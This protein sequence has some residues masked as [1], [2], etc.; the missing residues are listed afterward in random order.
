MS[1]A[2]DAGSRYI[3]KGLDF[4]CIGLTVSI[5]RDLLQPTTSGCT[6]YRAVAR[7]A[8]RIP[9]RFAAKAN[10]FPESSYGATRVTLILADGRV[11]ENVILSGPDIVRVEG[12]DVSHERAL[13]FRPSDIVDVV[14]SH[15][16]LSRLRVFLDVLFRPRR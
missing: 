15:K 2:N 13:D 8:V 1:L 6:R 7:V 14:S 11:V 4:N 9:K 12:R 3:N 10:S 5:G 16:R